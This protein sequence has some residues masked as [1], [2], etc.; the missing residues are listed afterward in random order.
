MD[1]QQNHN[2]PDRGRQNGGPG[3][4]K[5]HSMFLVFLV[6]TLITLLIMGFVNNMLRDTT[7]QEIS[8]DEF[9]TMLEAGN[10]EEVEVESTRL[11]IRAS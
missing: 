7:S 9:L 10:V 1:N 6:V 2:G 3:N 11:S 8:Y 4:N 5:N